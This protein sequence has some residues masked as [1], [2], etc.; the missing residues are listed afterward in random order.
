[1]GNWIAGPNL[2]TVILLDVAYIGMCGNKSE[3]GN[4]I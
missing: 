2:K 3:Y 1:M 4:Q